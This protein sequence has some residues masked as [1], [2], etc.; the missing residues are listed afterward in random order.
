MK[1]ESSTNSSSPDAGAADA[2]LSAFSR[3]GDRLR[4]IE[5]EPGDRLRR[6]L[7]GLGRDLRAVEP[8]KTASCAWLETAISA[9]PPETASLI[10][11]FAPLADLASWNEGPREGGPDEF[12]DAYAYAT[13]V[14]FDGLVDTGKCRSGLYI[15]RPGVYYPAHAHDAE[16]LYFILSGEAEWQAGERRFTA[17]PGMLIHHASAEPHIM[18]TG[19]QPL[20]AIFAWLGALNGRFWYP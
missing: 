11:G 19:E 7:G 6:A 13:L 18:E 9:R 17:K 10:D 12:T 15:Q 14:G 2:V 4:E 20:L 5:S 1:N 3:Y 16:E 8:G